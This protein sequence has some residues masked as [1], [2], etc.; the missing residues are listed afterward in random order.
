MSSNALEKAASVRRT[1]G[2]QIKTIQADRDLTPIAKGRRIAE[3]RQK[4]NDEVARLRSEHAKSV[5]ST[6]ESLHRRLFGLGFR[7]G[8]S[9]GEKAQVM[10]SYRDA[11]FRVDG[12]KPEEAQA[13]LSRAR[14]VGD[15]L[16]AKAIGAVAFDKGWQRVLED[17]ASAEDCH[18]E[19]QELKDFE[20]H[21]TTL[22]DG[23]RETIL[24]FSGIPEQPEESVARAAEISAAS[25]TGSPQRAAR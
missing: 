4:S 11:L 15:K 2:E 14:M 25:A 5:A 10:T 7:A 23:V 3:I 8:I 22:Q 6:R 18:S 12:L 20:R 1:A 17:Y 9:E 13:A 19:L 24:G 21:T 16:L